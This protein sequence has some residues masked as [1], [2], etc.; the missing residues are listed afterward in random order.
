MQAYKT[1]FY[2]MEKLSFL[3]FVINSSATASTLQHHTILSLLLYFCS[4]RATHFSNI[5]FKI[6]FCITHTSLWDLS[7]LTSKIEARDQ[8]GLGCMGRA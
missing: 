3:F 6:F 2:F 5:A 1:L 7:A 8:S 4:G